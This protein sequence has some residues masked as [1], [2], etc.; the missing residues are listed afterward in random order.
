MFD[1]DGA[2]CLMANTAECCSLMLK[3]DLRR[4]LLENVIFRQNISVLIVDVWWTSELEGELF[5]LKQ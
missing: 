3:V 1:P 5:C 4:S 2:S